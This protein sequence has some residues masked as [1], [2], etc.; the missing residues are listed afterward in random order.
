MSHIVLGEN[1]KRKIKGFRKGK[2]M[3]FHLIVDAP[4]KFSLIFLVRKMLLVWRR[5][6]ST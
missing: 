5:M 4:K 3:F 1:E 2:T 6:F